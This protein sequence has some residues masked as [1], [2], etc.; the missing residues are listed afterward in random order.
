MVVVEQTRF[1]VKLLARVPQVEAHCA[2]VADL[3]CSSQARPDPAC[4]GRGRLQ[5]AKAGDRPLPYSVAVAVG[6]SPGG[7]QVV[8]VDG[9]QGLADLYG[10]APRALESKK[11]RAGY[12]WGF[13]DQTARWC[14]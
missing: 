8:G 6:Q 2:G 11:Y 3:A 14:W 13:F 9:V 5:L 1:T 4:V 12:A 10:E 7:V